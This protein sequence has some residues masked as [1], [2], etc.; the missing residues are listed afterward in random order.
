MSLRTRE[1]AAPGAQEAAIAP[2][3]GKRGRSPISMA[4]LASRIITLAAENKSGQRLGEKGRRTRQ[5][6]ITATQ[7]L[8]EASGGLVPASAAI[9]RAADVTAPTFNLYFKDIG[10]AVLAVIQPMDSE[11]RPVLD[12]LTADWPPEALF[13]HARAFVA[14]YFKY[15][16][17]HAALLRVRNRLADDG[18]QRFVRLRLESADPL[19]AAMAAKVGVPVAQSYILGDRMD[20]AALLIVVLERLATVTALRTY[21]SMPKNQPRSI[22]ILALMITNAID[23][24]QSE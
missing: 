7:S 8:I 13:K 9:A 4:P 23:S 15:W 20:V 2:A 5:R 22:D 14:A 3:T 6:I 12:L 24:A 1:P 21:P 16:K 11:L 17:T 18:D 10:E 19:I